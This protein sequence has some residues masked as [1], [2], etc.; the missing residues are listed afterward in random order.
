M[1]RRVSDDGGET[2][3][4]LIMAVAIMGIAVIAIVGG[5][6]ISVLLSGTHRK[7]ATAG[8][9]VRDYA[10]L[11]ENAVAGGGYTT[12][13]GTGSFPAYAPG[14]GYTA[15]IAKVEYWTGS[16]WSGSCSPDT[17]LQ[18]LTLK[19]ASSDSG[20]G[21]GAAE[22]VSVVIRKPCRPTDPAC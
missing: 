17:G 13:A 14:A 19:V 5:L 9:Q 10:E 2:L 15:S 6:V 21:H 7:Q 11:I 22:T 3:I 12:C 4:E 1:R 8:A 16:A 20:S 18:R